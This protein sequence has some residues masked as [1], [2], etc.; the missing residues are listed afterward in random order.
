MISMTSLPL[1]EKYFQ[2]RSELLQGNEKLSSPFLCGF[3]NQ[4]NVLI[5]SQYIMQ[6]NVHTNVY[7]MCCTIKQ[8]HNETPPLPHQEQNKQLPRSKT[9]AISVVA[10]LFLRCEKINYE[11]LLDIQTSSL[12][13]MII[14]ASKSHQFNIFTC[15]CDKTS[16]KQRC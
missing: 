4:G 13:E 10:S 16:H 12:T 14:L 11:P 3:Q 7:V 8:T 6:M 2:L 9:T 15:L 1:L 5:C